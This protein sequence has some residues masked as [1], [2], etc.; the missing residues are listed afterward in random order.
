[1]SNNITDTWVETAP[2]L[3]SR[4]PQPWTNTRDFIT[5][6]GPGMLSQGTRNTAL[7]P[8]EEVCFGLQLAGGADQI[9]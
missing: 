4:G 6:A 9:G 2:P 3:L 5:Q 8:P 7:L 1:M